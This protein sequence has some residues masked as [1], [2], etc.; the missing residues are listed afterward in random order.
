MNPNCKPVIE[1]LSLHPNPDLP[2]LEAIKH[3]KHL[4]G[5]PTCQ[6]EVEKTLYTAAVLE[7][8]PEPGPPQIL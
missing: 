8:L 2:H 6:K 5:C 1:N 3:N 4:V 7:N